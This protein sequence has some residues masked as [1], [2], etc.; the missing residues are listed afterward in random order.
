MSRLYP[1]LQIRI[2]SVWHRHFSVY[3]KNLLSNGLPPFLEPFIFLM[4]IGLGLGRYVVD[5]N[6]ISYIQFLATGLLVTSAMFTASF[7]CTYGT[8][9]RLE[10]N[11]IYEGMLAAS[12]TVNDLI[13]GEI[14]W[15]GTKG[16]F[17]STAVLLIVAFF[18]LVPLPFSFIAPLIGFLTGLM[19][20]TL[21]LFISTLVSNINQFNFFFTG[22][23]SPMFFFS[24]VVF[25]LSSLPKI[26]QGIAEVFPLT[27]SVRLVRAICSGSF[28]YPLLFDFLYI[29][30]VIVFFG[31]LSIRR[32]SRKLVA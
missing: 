10:F 25:P 3:V 23:L 1:P 32:L 21:G 27:H 18:G 30:S 13:I 11:N 26:V 4:G 7:E 17:F 6:G 20:A 29:V 15:A 16:L 8:Y 12:I 19:F 2:L 28:P 14:F 31:A 9:I 24:G 5:I 22:F